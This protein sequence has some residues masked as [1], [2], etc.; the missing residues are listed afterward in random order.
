MAN[1]LSS[2]NSLL[3]NHFLEEELIQ[4]KHKIYKR[5]Q[6]QKDVKQNGTL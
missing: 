4:G 2:Y 6:K 3:L 5:V 1:F